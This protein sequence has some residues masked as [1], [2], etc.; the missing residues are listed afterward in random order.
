MAVLKNQGLFEQALDVLDVLEEKNEK[1][2][3]IEQERKTIKALIKKSKEA[4]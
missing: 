3:R 4:E 2:E 1:K